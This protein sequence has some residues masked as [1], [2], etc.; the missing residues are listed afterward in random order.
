MPERRSLCRH[1]VT[2]VNNTN[3]ARAERKFSLK[4]TNLSSRS[5]QLRLHCVADALTTRDV[6]APEV[7]VF[8]FSSGT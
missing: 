6:L 3:Y 7:D 1:D 2:G 4:L 5:Q 8:P